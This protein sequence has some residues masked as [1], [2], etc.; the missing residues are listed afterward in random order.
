M[1]DNPFDQLGLKKEIVVFLQQTGQLDDFLK[2]YVRL[3]Q[4]KVH[5]DKGG[6]GGLSSLV[7]SAYAEI[8]QHPDQISQW[9][10]TMQNGHNEYKDALEALV[11]E[12]E[13]M[14]KE[15]EKLR[16]QVAAGFAARAGS[17]DATVRAAP[18]RPPRVDP[19]VRTPPR[20]TAPSPTTT[21]TPE[22]LI[23]GYTLMPPFS[24]YALGMDALRSI[25]K[26]PFT[27]KENILARVEAYK[28]CD[29]SLF[30]T[31][32]DSSCGIVY[33]AG[34][35]KFKLVLDCK[36]LGD[37]PSDFSQN[38]LPVEYDKIDGVELDRGTRLFRLFRRTAKY[39]T[40]LS[41]AEIMEH[42]AWLA[43]VE[44]DKPLLKEYTDIVFNEYETEY[45][46]T[47]R[48]MGFYVQQNTKED[49]LRTVFVDYLDSG[50]CASGCYSLHSDGCF[51]RR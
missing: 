21:S 13:R 16:A 15:N 17:V 28:S 36:Q 44:E 48:L 42:P 38:Y 49:E 33:K 50:S 9:L 22:D 46:E 2:S 12:I 5:P 23:A 7:N 26:K 10:S 45:D 43:V 37:I 20:A 4:L 1:S 3:V 40:L 8:Q 30:D 24:T 31:W 6:D 34:T 47:D 41:E 39:N 19:H 11:P 29:Q 35:T 27:F 18:P 25:G 14:Q 51:L 32:L